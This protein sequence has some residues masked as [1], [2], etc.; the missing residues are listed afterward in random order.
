[1]KKIILIVLLVLI[2]LNVYANEDYFEKFTYDE[3]LGAINEGKN[4]IEGSELWENIYG[5]IALEVRDN[6]IILIEIIIISIIYTLFMS[7]DT[8]DEKSEL[9]KAATMAFNAVI[10]I[11]VIGGFNKAFDMG[12][13]FINN[14][15]VFSN[16]TIPV[17]G[18][19]IAASGNIPVITVMSPVILFFVNLIENIINYVILPALLASVIVFSAGNFSGNK[20]LVSFSKLI[21]KASVWSVTGLTTIY[22]AILGTLKIYSGTLSATAAKGLKF[23]VSSLIPVLGSV[24]SDSAEAIVGGAVLLKNT[25]GTAA[26]IFIIISMVVPVIKLSA[27]VFLYKIA[28]AALLM[29]KNEYSSNMLSDFSD[30]ICVLIGLCVLV[31]A[32]SLISVSLLINASDMGVGLR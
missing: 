32:M 16:T 18:A 5:L 2:P 13:K 23:A 24:L 8:N 29:M 26:L 17:L 27:I 15:T 22:C 7:M 19:F 10:F 30:T 25:A 12:S 28:S 21:R 6:M 11:M 9:S 20:G 14:I 3:N 31:C 4:L 1:M